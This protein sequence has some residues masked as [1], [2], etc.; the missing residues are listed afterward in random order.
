MSL[1]VGALVKGDRSPVTVA[2]F[3]AQAVINHALAQAF[4]AL[5]VVGEEGVELL[6]QDVGLRRQVVEAVAAT[7]PQLGE[8]DI[9][10][11][12]GRGGHGG[13]TGEAFWTV[14]PIDG[15]KGFLRGEQYAVAIALIE[16]GEVL[17]GVLACPNLPL[18]LGE[19][20]SPRGCLLAAVRGGGG[21]MQPLNGGPRRPLAVAPPADPRQ[22]VVCESVEAAHSSHGHSAA[23]RQRL[24]VVPPPLRMDSQCKY[25]LLARGEAAIYLRLPTRAGYRE[26]IWDH[27][28]GVLLLE[29]A[30]GRVTDAYGR[31]LDFS[32]GRTLAAN[33]G[34]VATNGHLHE[35][36]LAAVAA[37]RPR[38]SPLI[39]P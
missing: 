30:G 17:L 25:A 22:A 26:K 36:V 23:V 7:V 31:E 12:L 38:P 20:N 6:Q 8:G 5:P 21:W 11:A 32:Q 4:P 13:G 33:R 28:A 10:V 37:V 9:L 24:G 35:Q 14:D 29:E 1:P 19:E 15:T 39:Q 18:A 27:A 16:G 3:A 34:V 2:D